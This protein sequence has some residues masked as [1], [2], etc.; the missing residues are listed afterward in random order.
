MRLT[1]E[2]GRERERRET[3]GKSERKK[4]KNESGGN[5]ENL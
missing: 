3:H 4:I 2:I 1:E 5:E